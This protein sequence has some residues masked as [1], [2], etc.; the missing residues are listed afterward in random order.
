MGSPGIDKLR[1]HRPVRPGDSIQTEV[2]VRDLRASESRSDRGYATLAYTVTNQD[3]ETVMTL[4]C[5][6]I[7]R[8]RPAPAG[9][10]D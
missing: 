7:L 2:E 1:W 4:A 8:R 10:P 3:G 5:T 6:H 9:T